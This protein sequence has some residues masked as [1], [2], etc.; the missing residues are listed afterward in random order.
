[1]ALQELSFIYFMGDPRSDYQYIVDEEEREKEVAKGLGMPATW[2]KDK[3]VQKALD[4]YNSFKPASAGLLED[5][6]VAVNKLRELLRNIDLGA[7]DDKGRPIYTLNTVTATI[8]QIPGLV[9]DLDEAERTLAK[10]IIEQAR[11]R[12]SQTKALG[13]DED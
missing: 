8:K 1:M 4:F 12:G 2:K 5:T 10:D 11:A 7:E 13:E 9:K 6:R 3:V